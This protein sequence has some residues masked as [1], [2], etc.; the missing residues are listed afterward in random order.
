MRVGSCSASENRSHGPF[1]AKGPRSHLQ[2]GPFLAAQPLHELGDNQGDVPL[3]ATTGLSLRRY[4]VA[5]SP[6]WHSGSARWA[7]LSCE[8]TA[9]A[10]TPKKGTSRF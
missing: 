7:A 10:A 1:V 6:S 2:L 4:D 8:C 3:R 9:L 5:R